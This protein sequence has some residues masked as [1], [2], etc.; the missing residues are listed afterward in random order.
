MALKTKP[1]EKNLK[2]LAGRVVE[3]KGTFIKMQEEVDINIKK[4]EATTDKKIKDIDTEIAILKAHK[5]ELKLS[6]AKTVKELTA[7]KEKI[8]SVQKNMF[9]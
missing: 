3:L 9:N 5:E 1:N 6:T 7:Q 2:K 8:A 4:V